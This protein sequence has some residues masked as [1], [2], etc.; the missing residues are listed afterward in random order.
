MIAHSSNILTKVDPAWLLREF[1]LPLVR[2]FA[3]RHLGQ[4]DAL[5]TSTIV[6]MNDGTID[7]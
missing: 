4:C 7:Y 2:E 1:V 6:M 3:P 5:R